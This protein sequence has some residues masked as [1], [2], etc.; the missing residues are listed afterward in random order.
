MSAAQATAG[1]TTCRLKVLTGRH[2]A[3][4]A[5][6][7][8]GIVTLGRSESCDIVLSDW[9][10][11]EI[12]I[13]MTPDG[14]AGQWQARPVDTS[15]WRPGPVGGTIDA[16]QPAV[17]G[18][19]VVAVGPSEAPWPSDDDLLARRHSAWP[20]WFNSVPGAGV[21]Q[22]V[23]QG[24]WGMAALALLVLPS[25]GVRGGPHAAA[26]RTPAPESAE[27]VQLLDRWQPEGL[28]YRVE[29]PF[30]V[31]SGLLPD[32]ATGR[33][34]ARHIEQL[35]A[36]MKVRHRYLVAPVAAATL[37]D[38]CAHPVQITYQGHATF[39]VEGRSPDLAAT[40]QRLTQAASEMGLAHVRFVDA[41]QRVESAA[42]AAANTQLKSR[43]LN[44][45]Q[46]PNGD[47]WID[48]RR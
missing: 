46:L 32:L 22:R 2:A 11:P 3:A 40:R 34:L 12:A 21:K 35:G 18:H 29:G 24:L 4:A 26:A 23:M 8:A 30:V 37:A 47:R 25:A 36:G 10:G 9:Q 16:W 27:L 39:R 1:A 7:P 41:L 28:T 19:I 33:E 45:V 13:A 42:S 48:I 14:Q 31:L 15:R 5:R 38:V 20:V 17:F 43:Q 44:Y 6:L